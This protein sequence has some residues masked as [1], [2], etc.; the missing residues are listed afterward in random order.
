MA[1]LMRMSVDYEG[2]MKADRL[3]LGEPVRKM[4]IM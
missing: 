3:S 4:H 2:R 1:I